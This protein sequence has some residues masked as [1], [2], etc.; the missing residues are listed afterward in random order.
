MSIQGIE[1]P[2]KTRSATAQPQ[3][4]GPDDTSEGSGT[5]A[6]L[7][8]KLEKILPQMEQMMAVLMRALGMKEPGAG[9]GADEGGGGGDC[10][11]SGS[12]GGGGSPSGA[13]GGG[14]PK[15]AGGGG[16]SPKGAGGSGSGP[17]P[18]TSG[19]KSSSSGPTHAEVDVNGDGK[20]DIAYNGANAQKFADQTKKDVQD[21]PGY[22]KEILA[23]AAA[24]P[25]GMT[26]VAIKDPSQMS[27]AGAAGVAPVG[28]KGVGTMEYGTHEMA[29]DTTPE[30]QMA[31]EAHEM[32][33]NNG[34]NHGSE[35]DAA[36]KSI[37]GS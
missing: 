15:G 17:A 16:G 25:S 26:Q 29:S 1:G 28:Q 35:M 31:V 13:G 7:K 3:V 30:N 34:H 9:G 14:S 23:N 37:T 4:Q 5:D 22:A 32:Q 36:V 18:N 6:E 11:A 19:A 24:N 27:M 21:H 20:N 10:P 8:R 12:G 2:S 33:H